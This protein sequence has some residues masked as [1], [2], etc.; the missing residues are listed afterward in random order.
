MP[1]AR[2]GQLIVSC[3][4]VNMFLSFALEKAPARLER[5]AAPAAALPA[6]NLMTPL[7]TMPGSHNMPQH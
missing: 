7:L 4:A 1:V 2:A 3:L 6:A 5:E